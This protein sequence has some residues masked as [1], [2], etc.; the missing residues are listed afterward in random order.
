MDLGNCPQRDAFTRTQNYKDETKSPGRSKKL[1]VP[2]VS[3]SEPNQGR[4]G[5]METHVCRKHQRGPPSEAR[6][7][8]SENQGQCES[9]SLEVGLT[10]GLPHDSQMF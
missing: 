7:P 5:A 9:F 4:V 10:L 8:K 2:E 1:A 3:I 6:G